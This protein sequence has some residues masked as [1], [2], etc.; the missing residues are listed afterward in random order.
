MGGNDYH[1]TG[2]NKENQLN[3]N[4]SDE[5]LDADWKYVRN[6]KFFCRW[7]QVFRLISASFHTIAEPFIRN[8]VNNLNKQLHES[9]LRLLESSQLFRRISCG[10]SII[11]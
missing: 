2:Q 5:K 6:W 7:S 3:S 10:F 4:H 8:T 1:Q 9:E 11:S